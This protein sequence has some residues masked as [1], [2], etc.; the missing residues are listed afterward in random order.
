MKLFNMSTFQEE[1]VS[2]WRWLFFWCNAYTLLCL[3][4][5]GLLSTQEGCIRVWRDVHLTRGRAAYVRKCKD[6]D[7]L[8]LD[9]LKVSGELRRCQ[10]DFQTAIRLWQGLGAS[11]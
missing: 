9:Y 8:Y 1:K 11:F 10:Q 2:F 4:K 7:Q 6:Y 3:Q 5:L